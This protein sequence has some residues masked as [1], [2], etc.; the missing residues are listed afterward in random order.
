MLVQRN[1]E[2]ARH[3][4]NARLSPM[5]RLKTMIFS[6]VDAHVD[7]AFVLGLEAGDAMVIRTLGGRITPA[8]LQ[9]IT[10]LLTAAQVLGANPGTFNLIVLHHT[11]YGI[12]PLVQKPDLLASYFGVDEADHQ[13][14]LTNFS[15]ACRLEAGRTRVRFRQRKEAAEASGDLGQDSFPL[16]VLLAR[17]LCG[18]SLSLAG[19]PA[20]SARSAIP[21]ASGGRTHTQSDDHRGALGSHGLWQAGRSSAQAHTSGKKDS[22]DHDGTGQTDQQTAP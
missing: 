19:G 1:Q 9:T 21:P 12:T 18:A 14:S 8:T 11:Q 13:K 3:Q 17:E 22:E 4:F 7:P 5:G 6:C 2:F 15:H 10:L 20:R 16:V